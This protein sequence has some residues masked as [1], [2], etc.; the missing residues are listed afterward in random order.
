M[1]E[2]LNVQARA[3]QGTRNSRRLRRK[4]LVPA[5]LYGHGQPS[6]SLTAQAENVQAVIRHG[7]RVVDLAGAV[8]E[9][10]FIRELQWDTYGT[11]VLHIDLARVSMDE[12][13]TVTVPVEMKGTAVGVSEGGVV[14][15]IVH[16]VEIECLAVSIP[17]KV[18]LK[19]NDMHLGGHMTASQIELP[20]GATMVTDGD[21]TIVHCVKHRDQAELGALGAGGAEPELIRK[22]EKEEKEG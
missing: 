2:V 11:E 14:E 12:R 3:E 5:N 4:G 21:I 10:A 15:L 7:A 16:E 6:V 9:K 18:V 19:I 22:P 8:T 1:S 17:D 13:V 20:A